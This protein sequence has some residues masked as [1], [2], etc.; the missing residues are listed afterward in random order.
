[1]ERVARNEQDVAVGA[2]RAKLIKEVDTEAVKL[3]FSTFQS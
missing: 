1:M 2:F 3:A